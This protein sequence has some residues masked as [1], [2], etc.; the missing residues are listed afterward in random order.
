[1]IL[2]AVALIPA[3][4]ASMSHNPTIFRI[5][6]ALIISLGHAATNRIYALG[7]GV[8]RTFVRNMAALKAAQRPLRRL[9]RPSSAPS[10]GNVPVEAWIHAGRKICSEDCR[11]EPA[12]YRRR[13]GGSLLP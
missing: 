8:G 7:G 12:E 11:Q 4:F 3:S 10:N 2:L 9:N 5:A 6:I 13:S 1:M